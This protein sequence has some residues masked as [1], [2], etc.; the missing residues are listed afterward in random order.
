MQPLSVGDPERTMLFL[1]LLGVFAYQGFQRGLIAEM[2]KL[3]LVFVGFAVGQPT[4]LGS[5]VVNVINNTY[6]TVRFMLGGSRGL[7]TS[8]A[9]TPQVQTQLIRAQNTDIALFIMMLALIGIGYLVS[10]KMKRSNPIMGLL[11][12]A[13]NGLVLTYFFLPALPDQVPIQP[14]VGAEAVISQSAPNMG[15]VGLQIALAPFALLYQ[16]VNTWIIP[17]IIV[18]ILFVALRSIKTH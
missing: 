4:L 14:P 9:G 16:Q 17:I 2:V 1:A 8:D 13:V 7:T 18:A 6:G 5:T 3:G 11:A 12:G 15:Q 10:A